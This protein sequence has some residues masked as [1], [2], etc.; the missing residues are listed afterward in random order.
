MHL[1]CTEFEA[2]TIESEIFTIPE[3]YREVSNGDMEQIINSLFT[4]E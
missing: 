2:K 4:K 1:S 3:D